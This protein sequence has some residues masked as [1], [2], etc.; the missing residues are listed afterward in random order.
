M[1]ISNLIPPKTRRTATSTVCRSPSASICSKTPPTSS[2]LRCEIDGEE[3]FKVIGRVDG[4]LWTAVYVW[5]GA[6]CRF[7]S[8]RKSN[9]KE[10]AEYDDCD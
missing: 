2:F 6:A 10:A 5:R 7:V 4:R 9:G 1:W 8:V 3:R